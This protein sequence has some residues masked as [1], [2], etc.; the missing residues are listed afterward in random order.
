MEGDSDKNVN[1]KKVFMHFSFI[2]SSSQ[3]LFFYKPTS[4][5]DRVKTNY[6]FSINF[7]S[8][9]TF[10]VQDKLIFLQ[11]FYEAIMIY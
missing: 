3:Y 6:I 7:L 10:R 1:A 9:D 11:E 4:T 5:R 8:W 2:S